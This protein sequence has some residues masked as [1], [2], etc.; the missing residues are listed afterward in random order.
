MPATVTVGPSPGVTRH[1][2]ARRGR[3]WAAAAVAAALVAALVAT[4]AHAAVLRVV[5]ASLGE[6]AYTHPCPG[7]ATVA[8]GS[9][10]TTLTLTLPSQACAGLTASLVVAD[11]TGKVVAAGSAQVQGAVATVTV[12]ALAATSSLRAS[13]TVGGWGLDTAWAFT[14][15]SG[16][17][18]PGTQTTVMTDIE[19]TLVTNNPVQACFVAHVTTTSPSPV[20]WSLTVDLTRPPYNG[21]APSELQLSGADSWRYTKATTTPARVTITGTS[22]GGRSTVVA[23][24]EHLVGVCSWSLPPG[25]QTPSAYSVSTAP[26]GTWTDRRACLLTTVTG[27]GTERFYFGWAADVDMTPA[28]DRLRAGG[29][30]LS[31]YSFGSNEWSLTRTATTTG[32][33]VVSRSPSNISG[34]GTISFTTCANSY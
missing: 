17:V 25:A 12:P 4:G 18:T 6:Y 26:T 2:L 10:P 22:S 16:P 34:T 24:Q 1:P 23:G 27:N 32:F 31:A 5:S 20:P 30:Q 8:P 29:R 9:S 11:P 21:A 7:S 15:P 14:A 19:W 3:R 13:A 33:H 28:L